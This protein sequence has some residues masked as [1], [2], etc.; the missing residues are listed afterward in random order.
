MST[1]ERDQLLVAAAAD[2]RETDSAGYLLNPEAAGHLA[3]MLL[4][5]TGSQSFSLVDSA[6]ALA[7]CLV[8]DESERMAT[9]D[10]H[11]DADA[12]FHGI[13]T[14]TDPERTSA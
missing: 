3:D 13:A 11:D 8:V 5:V 9:A 12:A 2:L 10:E 4:W 14:T 6:T 7:E 1:V